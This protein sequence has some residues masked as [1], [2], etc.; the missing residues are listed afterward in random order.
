M[1]C[2]SHCLGENSSFPTQHIESGKEWVGIGVARIN[3]KWTGSTKELSLAMSHSLFLVINCNILRDISM[4]EGS[5]T[6]SKLAK[7]SLAHQLSNQKLIFVPLPTFH[8]TPFRNWCQ[9]LSIHF[10]T[11]ESIFFSSTAKKKFHEVGTLLAFVPPKGFDRRIVSKLIYLKS[12]LLTAFIFL[13]PR[14]PVFLGRQTLSEDTIGS[15]LFSWDFFQKN[16]LLILSICL[17]VSL[18]SWK[19]CIVCAGTDSM[20][21]WISATPPALETC[22]VFHQ[23]NLSDV[24]LTS[25]EKVSIVGVPLKTGHPRYFPRLS[26]RV[27]LKTD[28]TICLSWIDAL[29][30]NVSDDL[31]KLMS[32][33]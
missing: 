28:D 3:C 9:F 1:S 15:P 4:R 27:M 8:L 32:S 10:H 11:Q 25:S 31:W 16:S 12:A 13:R 14:P 23:C 26:W 29:L 2:L 19:H 20:L 6:L 24:L 18:G 22:R 5:V 33:P 17:F 7:L 30:E 21:A